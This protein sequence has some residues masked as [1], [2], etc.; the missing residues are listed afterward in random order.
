MVFEVDFLL[1]ICDSERKIFRMWW[2]L[3]KYVIPAC[4]IQRG[5]FLYRKQ[6]CTKGWFVHQKK[7][8]WIVECN[9]KYIHSVC[10]KVCA[11]GCSR[12][13]CKPSFCKYNTF[14]QNLFNMSSQGYFA[15]LLFVY[16][17]LYFLLCKA[18]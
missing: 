11:L 13:L 2:H 5:A 16:R 17:C 14:L 3:K 8:M 9:N 7:T 1:H 4:C 15:L 18:T 12:D 10:E 6:N